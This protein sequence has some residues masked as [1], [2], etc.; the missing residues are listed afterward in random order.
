MSDIISITFHLVVVAGLYKLVGV[1]YAD[2]MPLINL[3]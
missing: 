3:L 1:I 2:W